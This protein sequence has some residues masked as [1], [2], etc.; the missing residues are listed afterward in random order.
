MV[1]DLV[2]LQLEPAAAAAAVVIGQDGCQYLA[3]QSRVLLAQL[4]Q[5]VHQLPAEQVAQRQS[6]AHS[7][8]A[9][10]A[11]AVDQPQPVYLQ[12]QIWAAQVVAAALIT[13]EPKRAAVMV[14]LY[15]STQ[16]Q[17]W[18]RGRPQAVQLDKLEAQVVAI[19][20]H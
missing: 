13:L 18:Q 10:V 20:D 3:Q 12:Q 17:L 4:E 8:S 9:A 15:F 19:L 6:I 2:L 1:A 16:E 14:R 7:L 5:L 11:A